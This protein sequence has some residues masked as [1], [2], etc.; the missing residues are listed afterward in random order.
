MCSMVSPTEG[1]T[2][3]KYSIKVYYDYCIFG[4]R[5]F[6]WYKTLW[7]TKNKQH[8]NTNHVTE[9]SPYNAIYNILLKNLAT[10]RV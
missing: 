3:I 9:L 2:C 1:A 5:P 8:K 6:R 10:Y 7:H 4:N